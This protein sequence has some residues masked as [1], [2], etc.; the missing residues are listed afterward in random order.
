MLGKRRR[1]IEEVTTPLLGRSKSFQN[2]RKGERC[3][4]GG[5]L[6]W[7]KKKG[8]R[9]AGWQHP[10]LTEKGKIRKTVPLSKRQDEK[11]NT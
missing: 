1:K 5:H 10:S 6:I 7:A 3:V 9:L 8:Q 4:R 2:L 11:K